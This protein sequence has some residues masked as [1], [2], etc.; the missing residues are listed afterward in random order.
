MTIQPL[1]TPA[2]PS[3]QAT[4]KLR[5]KLP[6]TEGTAA[7]PASFDFCLPGFALYPGHFHLVM[8]RLPLR[9]ISSPFWSHTKNT[10]DPLGCL[11]SS[12]LSS[13]YW[14]QPLAQTL[15]CELCRRTHEFMQ[16][17][18]HSRKGNSLS[19]MRTQGSKPSP[20]TKCCPLPRGSVQLHT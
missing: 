2:S 5:G 19:R 6:A 16:G 18:V 12:A 1:K 17:T 9:I 8:G 14:A 15:K 7:P 10:Q 4:R 3:D 11:P 13:R 20:G